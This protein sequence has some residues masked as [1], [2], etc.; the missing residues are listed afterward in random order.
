M[1]TAQLRRWAGQSA[2]LTATRGDLLRMRARLARPGNGPRI[3]VNSLPKAGTHLLMT[4]LDSFPGARFSGTHFMKRRV[5]LDDPEI[6]EQD[7][8][9]DWGLARLVLDRAAKG[10]QYVTSHVWGHE[11]LIEL[12]DELGYV[13]IF[14]VRDPRDIVV[15]TAA[16][17]SRLRRHMH[18]RRFVHEFPTEAEQHLAIITG[19]PPGPRGPG[20]LP[21]R[22]KLEGF[23]PWLDAPGVLRCRY[24]DLIGERGGGSRASQL[25][26]VEEIGRAIGMAVGGRSAEEIA[27]RAWSESSA[28]FRTGRTG[29]WRERLDR[30]A[31]EAFRSSI[32]ADLLGAYGYAH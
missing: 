15:S 11:R 6:P 13:S 20:R 24:E 3:F 26:L 29:E 18:H 27:A 30:S 23:A 25:R 7:P 9:L 28:T 19:Y 21:L 4:V 14:V 2:R 16:Y 10:G 12:L 32:D 5:L 1:T 22:D 8:N 31:L 17:I